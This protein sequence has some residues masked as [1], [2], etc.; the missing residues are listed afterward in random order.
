M[1]KFMNVWLTP[2]K[3][4]YALGQSRSELNYQH[5][6]SI[7]MCSQLFLQVVSPK[8]VSLCFLQY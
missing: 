1:N 6:C 8:Q 2:E 7:K 4:W 5:I 3:G